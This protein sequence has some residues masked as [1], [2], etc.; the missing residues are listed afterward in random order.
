MKTLSLLLFLLISTQI[1]GLC[2]LEECGRSL[3]VPNYLC[4]DGI[5]I[6]GPSDCIQNEAGQCDWEIIT[7][8]VSSYIGYLRS[9]EASFCM[10]ACAYFY[11]ETE[12]GEYLTKVTS[13]DNIESLTYFTDRYV[14]L[15]G[16]D[17]WCVECGA[18]DVE[19]IHIS[20]ACSNPVDC[21]Q[22]PC[23]IENCLA[24]PNSECV[25]N[26]CDGCHADYYNGNGELITDCGET[27]SCSGDNPAGCF[28]NGCPNG[29][30]CIDEWEDNCVSSNCSCD[31]ITGQWIC[32]TDC[33]GGTCVDVDV[34]EGCGISSSCD[35]CTDSGCF[36]QSAGKGICSEECMIADLAC[37]GSA[38]TWEAEC[39]EASECIDLSGLDFGVCTAVLGV[40]YA[41]GLCHP[42]SGC[43]EVL[44]GLDYSD[45]FFDSISECE[46]ACGDENV[47]CE[48]ITSTYEKLHSGK[49]A[50]C[51]FDNDCISVGGACD[52][53][54]GGC[55]YSVNID[56]Y[57]EDKVDELVDVWIQGDCTTWVCRCSA[58]PY[59]QCIDGTC[60][61]AYCMSSNPAGCFQTGCDDGYECVI[62]P[63]EC[64]PSWCSCDRS[65]GNWYCT[66]DCG[67]GS[68]IAAAVMGDV[69][70]DGQINVLDI[71]FAVELI[72]YEEYNPL[73]DLNVDDQL[74][75]SDIVMLIKKI[76]NPPMPE[77]C[78]IIPEIGPCEGI[79]PTYFF[80]QETSQCEEYITGCCGVEAFNLMLDCEEA[81][82]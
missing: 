56:N 64:L 66:K 55:H 1:Y 68:C 11:I 36:W 22:D 78:Y 60:T 61:S 42:I 31:E 80:N 37:Y 72:L 38:P 67:G 43:G 28:Q 2:T 17:V 20:D 35:D 75:V 32:T 40:G 70:N 27:S 59:A 12:S 39:P 65:Y 74:N 48:E 69:N 8:P 63:D 44:D 50:T 18:V 41:A 3:M 47:T 76:L 16:E 71:V 29:Y 19:E 45:A 23:L 53:G 49:Y 54:L 10:D 5:T 73:G 77:D 62:D 7:C 21:F 13:L 15:D 4:S 52:V 82:E 24:Y 51:E 46:A 34:T 26:Y 14:Y 81:C 9:I 58:E 33:N 57:P 6:A 25:A 30:K 79:C